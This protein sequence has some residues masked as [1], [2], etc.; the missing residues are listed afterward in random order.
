MFGFHMNFKRVLSGDFIITMFAK[1]SGRFMFRLLVS[2]QIGFMRGFVVT[3]VT[4]VHDA[5]MLR[6]DMYLQ[7]VFLLEIHIANI[8]SKQSVWMLCLNVSS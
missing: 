7:T 4:H 2:S 1:E 6:L 8:T 5:P 3:L